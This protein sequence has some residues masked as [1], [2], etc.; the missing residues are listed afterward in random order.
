VLVTVGGPRGAIGSRDRIKIGDAMSGIFDPA[1][2]NARDRPQ[3]PQI[4]WIATI[5]AG[6]DGKCATC[7]TTRHKSQ[8]SVVG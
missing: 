1:M 5:A 6:T 2:A 7:V 4:R 8:L 3:K